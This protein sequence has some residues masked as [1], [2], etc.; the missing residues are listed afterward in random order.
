MAGMNFC[1]EEIVK[2]AIAIEMKANKFYLAA[3]ATAKDNQL[4]SFLETLAAMEVGH[5]RMF[6]DIEKHLSDEERKVEI[7]DPG[8]EMAFY[9]DKFTEMQAWEAEPPTDVYDDADVMMRI[10]R[11][12]LK[13]EKETVVFYTFLY[14]FV[15]P[16]RGL[17]KVSAIIREERNHVAKLQNIIDQI[18]K[19]NQPGN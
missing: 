12:A 3:A 14:D 5:A 6:E 2:R 4:R 19:E 18:T 10:L 17:D 13:A 16:E 7:Y 1:A 8:S 15:R 11:S 9:L